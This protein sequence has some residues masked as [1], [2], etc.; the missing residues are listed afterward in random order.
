MLDG[1][2]GKWIVCEKIGGWGKFTY[3]KGG[4]GEG[5]WWVGEMSLSAI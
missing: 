2:V 4:R 1:L 5:V 3:D